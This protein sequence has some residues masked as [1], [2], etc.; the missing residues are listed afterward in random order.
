LSAAAPLLTAAALWGL[1]QKDLH[2]SAPMPLESPSIDLGTPEGGVTLGDPAPSALDAIPA[3]GGV[4][5]IPTVV[6]PTP[7]RVWLSGLIRSVTPDDVEAAIPPSVFDR[8]ERGPTP[9]ELQRR[10]ERRKAREL[11]KKPA[12]R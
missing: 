7:R 5:P 8:I 9:E 12:P 10:E 6:P 1:S 2:H 4:E 11:R 3:P